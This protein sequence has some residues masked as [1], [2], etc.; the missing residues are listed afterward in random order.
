V[1]SCH[2]DLH[3][4]NVLLGVDQQMWIVDCDEK[5]LTSKERAFIDLFAS[6][7]I[8]A[9]ATASDRETIAR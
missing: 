1:D 2:A 4:W 7:N 3:T 5:M 8:V 6:G 9:I